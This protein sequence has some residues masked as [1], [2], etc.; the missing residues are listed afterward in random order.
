MNLKKIL[1]SVFI[2]FFISVTFIF[3]QQQSETT[4]KEKIINLASFIEESCR[5]YPSFASILNESL[6]LRYIEDA[7]LPSND[8]T[9]STDLGYYNNP[10]TDKSGAGNKLNI[11]KLFPK[12]GT[13]A[14]AEWQFAP[15]ISDPSSSL[16][17]AIYQ[18]IARNAFGKAYSLEGIRVASRKKILE[19]QI[20]EAYEDL[21]AVLLQQYYT[22]VSALANLATAQNTYNE[23]LKLMENM[24]KRRA[25]HIAGNLDI[26]QVKVTVLTRKETLIDAQAAYDRSTR[27]I[28][29][30][31]RYKSNEEIKPGT[32]SINLILNNNFDTLFKEITIDFRTF[33]ILD[34]LEKAGLTTVEINKR[35]LLPSAQL[36]AS[37]NYGGTGYLPGKDIEKSF[38]VGIS[39]SKAFPDRKNKAAAETASIDYRQ[40]V[41]N[42]E[43]T[44]DNL[45]LNLFELYKDIKRTEQLSL[46]YE[47]K[48][49]AAEQVLKEQEKDYSIGKSSLKDYIDSINSYDTVK[50]GIESLKSIYNSYKIE[51]LRLTDS[52]VRAEMASLINE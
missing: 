2:F 20:T 49:F 18:D 23:S 17:A 51:W 36:F 1:Q 6:Y 16:S 3:A 5:A 39:L 44:R 46:L 50:Y 25:S 28:K 34:E 12:T 22:W 26:N 40:T 43:I 33:E 15:G 29:D 31:M 27:K 35:T 13:T 7:E 45:R 19:Y 52:L 41:L 8:F 30:F 37:Y 38:S 47:E 4:G 32:P 48:L 24:E 11:S 21:L 14:S 42:N 9:V 10:D